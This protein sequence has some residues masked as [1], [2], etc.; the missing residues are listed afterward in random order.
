MADAL[1]DRVERLAEAISAQGRVMAMMLGHQ[2]L[3][4]EMLAKVLEAVTKEADGELGDLLSKLVRDSA[5]HTEKLDAIL[6][7]VYSE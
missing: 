2:K 1:G 7:R 6:E 4:N 5:I 3:H